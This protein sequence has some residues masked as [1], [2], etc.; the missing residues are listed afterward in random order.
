[1]R[2][3]VKHGHDTGHSDMTILKNLD[4]TQHNRDMSIS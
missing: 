4:T 2:V 3:G 1:M